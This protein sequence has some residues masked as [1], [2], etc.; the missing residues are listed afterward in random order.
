MNNFLQVIEGMI[1]KGR[2]REKT[3]ACRKCRDEGRLLWF[4]WVRNQW[5]GGEWQSRP[6]R[7]VCRA[8][9]QFT[10]LPNTDEKKSSEGIVYWDS[11]I[12][13]NI[14]LN[15]SECRVK[16]VRT[17][18]GSVVY[19]HEDQAWLLERA[20]NGLPFHNPL[21]HE[22]P[23]EVYQS[24]QSLMPE[25]I[26]DEWCDRYENGPPIRRAD[27]Q[28]QEEDE[29]ETEPPN[30]PEHEPDFE[31]DYVDEQEDEG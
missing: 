31:P 19:F 3:F 26:S 23:W 21:H 13:L 30:E 12:E 1:D 17:D 10:P 8:G 28:Q 2:I 15:A 9:D 6:L 24:I 29:P 7:C 14:K 22:H 5:H 11:E 4:R 16:A 27:I 18:A 25:Y 20:L